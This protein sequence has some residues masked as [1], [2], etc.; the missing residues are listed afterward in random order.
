M[1]V[2][3]KG[4]NDASRGAARHRSWWSVLSSFSRTNLSPFTKDFRG[5]GHY[6]S[7]KEFFLVPDGFPS[8][9]YTVPHEH[10]RCGHFRSLPKIASLREIRVAHLGVEI[11]RGNRSSHRNESSRRNRRIFARLLVPFMQVERLIYWDG[12]SFQCRVPARRFEN[13]P[14]NRISFATQ[15]FF[16][17]CISSSWDHECFN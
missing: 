9:R 12:E 6:D 8:G 10:L 5:G 16:L 3:A 1:R 17:R 7:A 4:R 14:R 13:A 2:F 15:I 11:L